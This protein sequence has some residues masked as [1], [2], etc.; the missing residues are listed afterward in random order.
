MS[1]FVSYSHKDQKWLDELKTWLEPLVR[2]NL[3]Q[4]GTTPTS[5][6]AMSGRTKSI[7]RW[8]RPRLRSVTHSR[9]W[10]Y[11]IKT[12]YLRY[13]TKLKPGA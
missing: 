3:I 8:L 12:N 5:A 9:L 4:I 2:R 6:P 10:I 7:S 1:I 13:S 11:L